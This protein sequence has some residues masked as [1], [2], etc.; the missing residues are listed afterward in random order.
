MQKRR[1]FLTVL[2]GLATT[3][4]VVAACGGG[5]TT[6]QVQAPQTTAPA[7]TQPPPAP[8]TTLPP[9]VSLGNYN[10]IKNGMTL[11]DV[12]KLL[13]PNQTGGTPSQA[14]PGET[15]YNWYA[16]GTGTEPYVSVFFGSN[17]LVTSKDQT[18]L[19]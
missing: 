13:G 18:G 17:G 14:A 6:K 19:H 7:V 12:E 9:G 3:T 11:A 2:A 10:A 15:L 1:R 5:G 16:N 4:V 8:T